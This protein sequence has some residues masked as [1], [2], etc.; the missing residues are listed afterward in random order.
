MAATDA[1]AQKLALS[2]QHIKVEDVSHHHA[3]PAAG[4]MAAAHFL[5]P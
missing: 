4:E 5:S 3:S 1:I 2:P